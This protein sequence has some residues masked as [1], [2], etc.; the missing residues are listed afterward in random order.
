MS[1]RFCQVDT[2][3][4]SMKWFLKMF[5]IATCLF[6]LTAFWYWADNQDYF[7]S[8]YNDLTE[9]QNGIFKWRSDIDDFDLP[10]VYRQHFA[11]TEFVFPRQQVSK[12]KLFK[13]N[14]ITGVFTSKTL[15]K[16]QIGN[17]LK[18]CNDTTNFDWGETTWGL[19]EAEYFIRL[20]NSKD[21]V[22]G[23]IYFCLTDCGHIH[24]RPFSPSMK[25]GELSSA[26]LD[27]I[28]NLIDDKDQ[29]E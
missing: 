18:I 16:N 1:V 24:A 10:Q 15:R 12:V 23:K 25:F 28:N 7:Q 11:D 29:W 2:V 8:N 22:V 27:K 20:Y 9:Q 14:P 6:A 17:F 4:R 19:D 13:N 3:E 21:K 26:G 5:L